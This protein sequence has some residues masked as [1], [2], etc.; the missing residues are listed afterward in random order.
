MYIRPNIGLLVHKYIN[1]NL[2][3]YLSRIATSVDR[4]I[5]WTWRTGTS[6]YGYTQKQSAHFQYSSSPG[7]RNFIQAITLLT[8]F[9][10]GGG[11]ACLFRIW[12]R[13]LTI[14]SDILCGFPQSL[15]AN[16]WT[17]SLPLTTLKSLPLTFL[18]LFANMTLSDAVWCEILALV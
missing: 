11:G 16:A 17:V 10:G 5:A 7:P 12:P 2:P 18:S 4:K 9:G 3:N 1:Y 15:Q 13:K 14:L 6:T 8:W